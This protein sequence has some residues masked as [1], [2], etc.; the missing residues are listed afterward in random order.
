MPINAY[1]RAVEKDLAAGIATEHTYRPALKTLVESLSDGVIA[2]NEPKQIKCGAPDFIV[3]R[4]DL[5]LGYIEAK[6][7]GKNLAEIEKDE[8]LT[9]YRDGLA[10]LIL[11]DYLEF[12]RYENGELVQE[13]RIGRPGSDGKINR[14]KDGIAKLRELFSAFFSAQAPAI[15]TPKDL[16]RHLAASARIIRQVTEDVFSA[17]D[18][19]HGSLHDQ[20]EA[21]RVTLIKDL[22]SE[23]FADMYAQTIVYGLFSA[24]V[25]HKGRIDSFTRQSAAY[26]IPKTNP[27]L[28]ALFEQIAGARL[29]ERLVWAVDHVARLLAQ[30]D[31]ASIL[32]DFGKRTRQQDPVVHFYETFLAAYDPKMREKRGVFY[33]PEPVVSYIVRS[34][35]AILKRDFG[36]ADGIAS[37]EKIPMPKAD[38][39][40]TRDDCHKVLIL[41]PACGTGTFLFNVVDHIHAEMERKGQ[42]GAWDLYV[43]EHLLPRLFGFELL[44]AP[45]TMAH[46]KLG[47]QLRELGYEFESD[48]RLK[49]YLTNSLEE[50][51]E[52]SK[53]M[54]FARAIEHE[55]NAAREVKNELPVMVILGNPPYSGLSVNKGKWIDNLLKHSLQTKSN[56]QSYYQVD[57]VPLSEKKVWLQ[58]DYVKFIRIAQYRIEKTGY[59]ILAFIT[60]NGYLDNPTFRGMRQSLLKTFDD[61]YIL[62]LHG[63]AKKKETA[64]DG[65]K[66]EN[67]FDIMQGVA[68]GIFVKRPNGE[69]NQNAVVQHADLWGTR[70]TKYSALS[71]Q[72]AQSIASMELEPK[73]PYYF[74]VPRDLSYED[75]FHSF[76]PITKILAA[77]VTGIVTSRDSLTIHFNK[78]SIWKTV[79][80]FVELSSEEAIELFK[81]PEDKNSWTTVEAKRDLLDRGPSEENL[82]KILYRPFDSRWT[83]YTGRTQGFLWRP[84]EEVM[85]HMLSGS[86]IAIST[87]R[88]IEIG[89]GWEHVFCSNMITQHHTVS[90]KEVNYLFPLY[91]YGDT[92]ERQTN[93]AKGFL[94]Q[95]KEKLGLEWVGDGHGD[96]E[97]S[98]GPED[99]FHYIYAIFH[100]PAYR[101]RYAGF[102]KIDFPRVPLTSDA[103]L[104]RA[105]VPLGHR[106][107]A[108]HTM[109]AKAEKLTRYP[110][111]GDHLVEKPPRYEA[112]TQRVYINKSQYFESVPPEVWEFHVGGYQVCHKWLKDRKGRHLSLEEINH[113]Q[114]VVAALAETI[115][116]M[117]RIDEVIE[118]RGGWPIQ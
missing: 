46:M 39:L 109:E 10:N 100:S 22:K 7:I 37:A 93:I 115:T 99:V 106:L 62:N 98:F 45:Y 112:K 69:T 49:V 3:S 11:T 78:D 43:R 27:F 88:S 4:N 44:M 60:N 67:V 102:L 71:M 2:T 20:L 1:L 16:A 24:R 110:E 61:I 18:E 40:Q 51:F 81:L 57:G 9:R 83:Y 107:T 94:G 42:G 96:L 105:L 21:F 38:L 86:N 87:T 30:A 31:M 104:F 73:S 80:K 77:Y 64:P 95:F 36:I 85:R 41:D 66:D 82:T 52:Q 70:E 34:V 17:E 47:L 5:P 63:N 54:A 116:L 65:S 56:G 111:S 58:D 32:A 33:T 6:D 91:L 79:C 26:D 12:R 84:R 25:H 97:S 108:L 117:G 114:D 29:D 101:E 92:T 35:D 15:N 75:E 28:R 68:V 8:Q 90:L 53:P 14:D 89:R 118:E 50:A 103:D 113:Y 59:G 76:T 55:S 74:Y 23:A 13:C 19:E 48:E 72:D